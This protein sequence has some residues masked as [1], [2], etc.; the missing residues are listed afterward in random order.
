MGLWEVLFS[1]Y[2]F[3][4]IL[5]SLIFSSGQSTWEWSLGHVFCE[6]EILIF[7][8][9]FSCCIFLDIFTLKP[10]S[11]LHDC[12]LKELLCRL[13]TAW[14]NSPH[15]LSTITWDLTYLPATAER[16]KA[17]VLSPSLYSVCDGGRIQ[18]RSG[19]VFLRGIGFCSFSLNII[20]CP[21]PGIAPVNEAYG[22]AF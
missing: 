14:E 4:I 7:L 19:A 2:Y 21:M 18:L 6:I 9:S 10:Q 1:V 20:F 17:C 15:P 22:D 13:P 16:L 12:C 11:L 5:F 3:Q 8:T